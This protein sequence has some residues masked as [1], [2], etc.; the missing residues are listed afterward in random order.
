MAD[1]PGIRYDRSWFSELRAEIAS[2]DDPG[3]LIQLVAARTLEAQADGLVELDPCTQSGN[4]ASYGELDQ[5]PGQLRMELRIP[6]RPS[7]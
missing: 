7:T 4:T 3:K 5:L 6:G 2:T 1:S